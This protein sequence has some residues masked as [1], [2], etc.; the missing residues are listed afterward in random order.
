MGGRA[1]GELENTF[2]VAHAAIGMMVGDFAPPIFFG[3]LKTP[4][5]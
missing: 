5:E 3:S 2:S 1:A 4:R